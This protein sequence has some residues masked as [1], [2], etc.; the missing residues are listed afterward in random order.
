MSPVRALLARLAPVVLAACSAAPLPPARPHAADPSPALPP[1]AS[2]P[3]SP[4]CSRASSASRPR[5]SPRRPRQR[6]RRSP[7]ER[8]L[9]LSRTGLPAV[10]GVG[11]RS[12]RDVHTSS[13]ALGQPGPMLLHWDGARTTDVPGPTCPGEFWGVT[14][15]D[16]DILLAG[17]VYG[18]GYTGTVTAR[19]RGRRGRCETSGRDQLV[20]TREGVLRF[21]DRR[22]T[23]RD[24][25]LPSLGT[26]FGDPY[27]RAARGWRPARPVMSGSTPSARPPSCTATAS[28]GSVA[29]RGWRGCTACASTRRARPG[30]WAARRSPP[31]GTWRSAGIARARLWRRLPAPEG[32]RGPGARA[33]GAGRVDPRQG[34]PLPLGRPRLPPRP[35]AAR[36]DQRGVALP[37]LAV[38]G[39][40]APRGRGRRSS[41][42]VEKKP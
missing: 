11:G 41:R 40:H 28:P 25:R 9:P 37:D 14:L 38:A 33:R 32:L 4:S 35:R 36:G 27:Y 2:D 5:R 31:K 20:P 17:S 21:H 18:E 7:L 39:G 12:D 16:G 26:Y 23:L 1:P 8:S 34:A 10:Y 15:T 6:S 19:R 3:R 42:L 22:V 13:R 29:R 24:E 30:S